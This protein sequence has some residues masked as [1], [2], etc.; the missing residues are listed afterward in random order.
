MCT[1]GL[2]LAVPG[3]IAGYYAAWQKYGALEWSS[4][5][6][7]VITLCKEGYRV[8]K[9]MAEAI[10]DTEQEIRAQSSLR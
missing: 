7:P 1:G 10:A 6:E 5:F 9:A 4:L 3:E 2:A 8:E